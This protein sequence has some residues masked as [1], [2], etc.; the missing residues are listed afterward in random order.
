[1]FP[2][3]RRGP[4]GDDAGGRQR[5]EIEEPSLEIEIAT[6]LVTLRPQWLADYLH[7]HGLSGA[8]HVLK[9]ESGL[10]GP[11]PVLSPAV[12][13]FRYAAFFPPG[14]QRSA[15]DLV[16]LQE[17][18]AVQS[19]V[20]ERRLGAGHDPLNASPV[21]AVQHALLGAVFHT[22]FHHHS[23]LEESQSGLT[24]KAGDD[25]LS[26][27]RTTGMGGGAL[28]ETVARKRADLRAAGTRQQSAVEPG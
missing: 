21:D 16:D 12:P 18:V 26:I 2:G 8:Q 25:Q 5:P 23:V 1:M 27:H 13:G 14:I 7:Q 17:G 6:D 24:R 28:A 22:Q 4:R 10:C 11:T 20:Q 9:P 15:R 19:D 3:A